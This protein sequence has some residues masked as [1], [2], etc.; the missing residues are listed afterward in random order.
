[1]KR[2]DEEN[3]D[4]AGNNDDENDFW[5]DF[6]DEITEAN[7]IEIDRQ[8]ELDVA[9]KQLNIEILEKSIKLTKGRWFF[10]IF[11]SKERRLKEIRATY[12]S[13]LKLVDNSL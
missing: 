6:G 10:W 4:F 8:E 1:M 7:I 3:F 9:H 11:S 13:L 2:W 5:M 12:R